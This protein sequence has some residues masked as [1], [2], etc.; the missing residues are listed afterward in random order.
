V[1]VDGLFWLACGGLLVTFVTSVGAYSLRSFSR[2]GLER[3]A[4]R[5]GVVERFGEILRAHENVALGVEHV[6]VL[7]VICVLAA[8]TSR[9]AF[10]WQ[11]DPTLALNLNRIAV[12]AVLAVTLV[13]A[14]IWVP[15]TVSRLWAEPVI[16]YGWRMWCLLA[17][18]ASPLSWLARMCDS[19]GHRLAGRLPETIN[20]ESFEEEIRTIVTEGHREG[21]LE[22]EAREMIEGVMELHDADVA[23][24]MTPRT[25]MQMIDADM[26]WDQI[27]QFVIQVRHTRIPVFGKNRDDIIGVLHTKDLIAELARPSDEPRRPF[28]ELLRKPF[29]VPET[30]AVDDLLQEFQ[31][32]R[33]HL[34]VVLDEYGGVS[35]LVTIEDVL[36]EI[37]G[38][39]VDEYDE[40][41][42]E[43]LQRIDEH[44]YEAL[45]RARV[46]EINQRL[47][48]DLP[49]DKD[50]DTIG[51]FLCSQMGHIPAPDEA[52]E[53]N[54]GVRITVV[55][56]SRRRINRV[57]IDGLQTHAREPA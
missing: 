37:V 27:L 11:H 39:I 50:F 42:E 29:F 6:Q 15:W 26:S 8:G 23:E 25:E 14:W 28:A 9:I 22:E 7:A 30:K 52:I 10:D 2:H 46:D 44:T 4:A 53:W 41:V 1:N 40:E 16:F 49:E 19:L 38:E 18:L 43:E 36:E 32:T 17:G 3:V 21:L 51:G 47:G 57:R 56:A 12:L 48:L 55:D 20:E 35:G 54:D 34:A 13:G 5:S 31:Q 24:V 33:S 45:G